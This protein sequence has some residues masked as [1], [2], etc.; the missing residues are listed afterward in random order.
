[1]DGLVPASALQHML[2]YICNNTR[3]SPNLHIQHYPCSRVREQWVRGIQKLLECPGD[4]VE[5]PSAPLHVNTLY[6]KHEKGIALNRYAYGSIRPI[7]TTVP[8]VFEIIS[9]TMHWF[10]KPLRTAQYYG[11]WAAG[12]YCFCRVSAVRPTDKHSVWSAGSNP[13]VHRVLVVVCR[14]F[15][16]TCARR[17][18]FYVGRARFKPAVDSAGTV[19]GRDFTT[20][21][22]STCARRHVFDL[23]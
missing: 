13:A 12:R 2:L 5:H 11:C 22:I 1:M 10:K 9:S 15:T 19:V 7:R 8:V 20:T 4:K 18:V 6:K 16:T 3:L 17:P 21:C 14:D 23:F